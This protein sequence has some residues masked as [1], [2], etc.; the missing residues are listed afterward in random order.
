MDTGAPSL[1]TEGQPT[2]MVHFRGLP[3]RGGRQTAVV[4]LRVVLRS[5]NLAA[6]APPPRLSGASFPR[7]LCG[8]WK[9]F[10]ASLRRLLELG[11]SHSLSMILI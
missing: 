7:E 3:H 10:R 8:Q 4:H 1:R 11:V 2:A 6:S 5:Q 9:V